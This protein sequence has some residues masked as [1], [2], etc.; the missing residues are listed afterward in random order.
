MKNTKTNCFVLISVWD[1]STENGST[2][3]LSGV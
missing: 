1:S 2:I 3:L